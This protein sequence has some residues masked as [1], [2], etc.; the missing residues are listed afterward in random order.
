MAVALLTHAGHC[1]RDAVIPIT[2][3]LFS[4]LAA[5]VVSPAAAQSGPA[6]SAELTAAWVG[7][8]DD[9]VVNEGLVGGGARMYILPR[10]SVGPEVVYIR[11]DNH[12]HWIATGNVTWDMFAPV[13]GRRHQVTPFVVAGVGV[14]QTRETFFGE[15][16]TS[17]EGAFTAGG[18]IRSV[19][20]DRIIMALDAR[21]GWELHLRVGAVVGVRFGK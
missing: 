16:L 7:F 8:A 18:G 11:G 9:G 10:L 5:P 1:S 6:P 12:S 14:F 20:N 3:A 4:I 13:N 19:L 21:V 15:T 17:N 2:I